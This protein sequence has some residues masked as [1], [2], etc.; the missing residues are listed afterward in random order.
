MTLATEVYE[1]SD[2]NVVLAHLKDALAKGSLGEFRAHWRGPRETALFFNGADAAAMKSAMMPVLL[3]EPLCKNA[4]V[5]VR[6]G[7]HPDGS[8]ETRI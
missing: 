6:Y 4:R 8:T 5:I 1:S 2:V 3:S 7:H